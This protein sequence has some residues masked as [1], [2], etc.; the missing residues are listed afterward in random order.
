MEK[1][2]V[3]KKYKVMNIINV[4]SLVLAA[5]LNI[6]V[7]YVPM[8]KPLGIVLSVITIL[9]IMYAIIFNLCVV[10]MFFK[11]RVEEKREAEKVEVK[12]EAKSEVKE[13]KASQ[14]TKT[15]GVSKP[16]TARTSRPKTT[17]GR[18][19]EK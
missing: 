15:S 3:T 13:E 16:K 19:N 8:P 12:T 11:D 6:V 5:V 10:V 9:A 2:V 14:K 1:I 17:A 18:K 7:A 4:V